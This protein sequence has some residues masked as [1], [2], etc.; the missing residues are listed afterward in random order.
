MKYAVLIPILLIMMSNLAAQSL[1]I[2][3][4]DRELER[5]A[6]EGQLS[7]NLLLAEGGR[8]LLRK[9]YGYADVDNQIPLREDAVFEL[10]SVSKQFTAAAVSLLVADGK[11]DLDAPVMDY[12]PELA[13]YPDLTTRQLVHHTGGLPDYMS[14]IDSVG[15]VPE[16]VTNTSVLDYLRDQ[17]PVAEFRAGEKFEYS[18]TG[19]LV[20]AS[21]IER[22]SGDIFGDFLKTRL[23]EPLGM[24]HSQ[25][26]RRRYEKDRTVDRFVPG[27]V[28]EGNRYVI[29][30]SLE[31]YKSVTTLDGVYG[32]GMVNS[33]LD[34]LYRWDRALARGEL[35]DTVLLFRPGITAG[36]DTTEYGY[37]QVIRQHPTYG[38]T[39]SHSGG[40]PGMVTYIYRFPETDRV[41]IFLR[42]DDG[43]HDPRITT[44]R[45]ALR[46][47]HGLPLMVEGL[48]PPEVESVD[49]AAVKELLGM[50]AVSPDFKLTFSLSDD[51]D[52]M[53]RA[54]G[55]SAL[56]LGKHPTEKDRY[57]LLEVSAELAFQ[58]DDAGRA[59]GVILY[60]GGQETLAVREE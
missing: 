48:Y 35:L 50:Y 33:T 25:V 53:V 45:S 1:S 57:I 16:F 37:G 32:D 29:P 11:I 31:E 60:Q 55:Q 13:A 30:D 41:L 12:L 19:Y 21:L 47:L 40:W 46:A 52:F 34:D 51:G 7:A 15:E 36:G 28:W 5:L 42:N 43:G 49:T 10:A 56:T 39:I 24:K 26:Y 3:S 58:R 8:I 6:A 20:L 4:L 54:T 27:Y 18:N 22:V 44:L 2:D 9:S 14:M 17:Q 38:Y 23:F 59:T